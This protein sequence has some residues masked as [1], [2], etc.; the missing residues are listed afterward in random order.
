MKTYSEMANNALSRIE[1]YQENK[2]KKRN[3]TIR[4]VVPILS[5]CL[6]ALIGA[7]VWKSGLFGQ[8]SPRSLGDRVIIS[9]QDASYRKTDPS[10][11][12]RVITQFA[13]DT[14]ACYSAPEN[15]QYFCFV[16]VEAARR[17]Y[18]NQ[19]VGFLLTF[20]LFARETDSKSNRNI[21]AEEMQEEYQR[22]SNEGYDFYQVRYW[23]YEGSDALNVQRSAIAVILTEEQLQQFHPNPHYGYAFRFITNGDGSGV[24]FP[25]SE[26]ITKFDTCFA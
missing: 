6:L 22:L 13:T 26:P 5:I 20:D 1:E 24:E 8:T 2:K 17:E 4:T 23:E 9:E 16:E 7:G 11:S 3:I 12:Q 25:A 19:S 18:A 10:T 21:S 14:A 15:G